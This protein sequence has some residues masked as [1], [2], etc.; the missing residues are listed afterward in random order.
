[1]GIIV[2]VQDRH[3][4]REYVEENLIGIAP[5]MLKGA[6]PNYMRDLRNCV[7]PPIFIPVKGNPS[8]VVIE[9][10][11]HPNTPNCG[12]TIFWLS[13]RSHSKSGKPCKRYYL[14]EATSTRRISMSEK[15]EKVCLED[16]VKKNSQKLLEW[17][18]TMVQSHYFGPRFSR[19][20]M[21]LFHQVKDFA[22]LLEAW[23]ASRETA[24]NVATMIERFRRND[25]FNRIGSL[26]IKSSKHWT[27]SEQIEYKEMVESSGDVTTIY[28]P[29]KGKLIEWIGFVPL[30]IG[31]DEGIKAVK[32]I[33]PGLTKQDLE[34]ISTDDRESI[35]RD[36]EKQRAKG[37]HAITREFLTDLGLKY[38]FTSGMNDTLNLKLRAVSTK[39]SIK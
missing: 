22:L 11:V 6:S 39:I 23:D 21:S 31:K 12:S 3:K 27:T 1:M 7:L 4:I 34:K 32:V 8:K 16:S 26:A 13:E 2:D 20:Q 36:F 18:R 35:K 37:D 9:I 10:D 15:K 14:R 28:E 38:G 30:D 29:K 19:W 25:T 17:E 33:L 24:S 5:K